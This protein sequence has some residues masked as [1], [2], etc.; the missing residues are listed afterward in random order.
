[1]AFLETAV[2]MWDEA[3]GPGDS[4]FVTVDGSVEDTRRVMARVHHWTESV[5]QV[6]QRPDAGTHR[7]GVA[8][9]KNTGLEL[10]MDRTRAEHL[11]LSD[12]DCWPLYTVSLDKHTDLGQP[13]SM[14]CWGKS[15]ALEPVDNVA[16]WSWPRGV[17]MYTQRSVVDRV[18]GMDE[19]F[20][21]GGHE[22][23]EWSQRIHNAGL[24]PA[25]FISPLSYITR[26]YMGARAL[27]SCVDM[28]LIGESGV[29]WRRRKKTNTSIRRAEGDWA[30]INAVMAGRVG[31]SDYVPYHAVANA[32]AWVTLGADLPSRGAEGQHE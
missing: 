4:L 17:M 13:H 21:P 11:F 20:G 19:R 10:M 15:R 28:P 24:T 2:R 23:V 16:S 31:S 7:L 9:N 6:G 3:L 32:R 25:P 12:D 22:H 8:V 18:G 14:V 29:S 26:N 30:R 1:M 27:W 5:Y